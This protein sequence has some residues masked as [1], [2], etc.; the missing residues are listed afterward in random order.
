MKNSKLEQEDVMDQELK[1]ALG[2]LLGQIYRVQKRI[3]ENDSD[4]CPVSGSTIYGL[5]NGIE[6]VIDENLPTNMAVSEDDINAVADVLQP[7]F[8]DPEK[9]S[10]FT[11]YYQIEPELESRAVSRLKAIR[12]LTYF[13]SGGSFTNV[14]EKMDSAN[15]P[16][17]CRTFRIHDYEK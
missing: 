8:D 6:P 1:R 15:S 10:E 12:I 11:G 14:I 4:I 7:Y 17:E 3:N 9:L 2:F 5:L 16:S 13:K